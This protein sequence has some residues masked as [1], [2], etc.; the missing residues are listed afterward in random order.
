ML[1]KDTNKEK[2]SRAVVM[3]QMVELLPRDTRDL[4]SANFYQTFVYCQLC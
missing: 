3:A 1:R 4:S 2:V